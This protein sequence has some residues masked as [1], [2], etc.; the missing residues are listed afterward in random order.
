MTME[1]EIYTMID[2][3]LGQL[4]KDH[5]GVYHQFP[6]YQTKTENALDLLTRHGLVIFMGDPKTHNAHI[7]PL[8]ERVINDFNGIENYIN[9]LNAKTEIKENL[10]LTRLTGEVEKLKYDISISRDTPKNTIIN[11]RIAIT[12]ILIALLSLA[13]S[14]ILLFKK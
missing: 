11:R 3:F 8:G 12:S 13:I 14:A 10:E 6:L 9:S 5:S 4:S 2:D 7:T 1:K